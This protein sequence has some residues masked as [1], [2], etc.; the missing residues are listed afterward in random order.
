[1]FFVPKKDGRW[2]MVVDYRKINKE[3]IPDAYPLPLISQ[4]TNDL[5]KAKFFTKLDLVGAYQL[6]RMALGQEPLTAFRTQYGMFE[7]LVVRDGLRNAPAVFQHFLNDIFKELLGRGVTIYIDDI[8]IY[9][10]ELAK[11]RRLTRKVFEIIRKASLY[12]K[13]SKCEFE[14]TS[15]AFLGYVISDKGVTIIHRTHQLL[16]PLCPQL[17]Q[18][19]KPDHLAHSKGQAVRMG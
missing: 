18:D 10:S 14:V 9:A 5:S 13:A 15:M 7:S 12:L 16:S 17:L 8:L 1:M 11:L 3:T 19:R 6:L 4:I 2:R